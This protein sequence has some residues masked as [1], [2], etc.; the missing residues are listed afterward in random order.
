VEVAA[1]IASLLIG[2]FTRYKSTQAIRGVIINVGV[3]ER[4]GGRR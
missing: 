4:N 1:R 3:I 2:K